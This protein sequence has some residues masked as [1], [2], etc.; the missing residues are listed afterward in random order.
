MSIKATHRIAW[1][2]SVHTKYEASWDILSLGFP[3][4]LPLPRPPLPDL[5]PLPRSPPARCIGRTCRASFISMSGTKTGSQKRHPVCSISSFGRGD[6]PWNYNKTHSRVFLIKFVGHTEMWIW[7]VDNRPPGEDVLSFQNPLKPSRNNVL[8]S[9]F[10]RKAVN[11]SY[12]EKAHNSSA[13]WL[14]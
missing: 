7:G 10:W 5:P 9:A 2:F 12:E 1:H 4:P 13:L 14:S 8:W 11:L 3:R 6:F